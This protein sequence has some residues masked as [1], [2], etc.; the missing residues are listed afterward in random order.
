[1]DGTNT[2]TALPF[3]GDYIRYTN[4]LFTNL[5]FWQKIVGE[6]VLIF[7][8]DSI[9]CSNT[10]H[11]I[12]DYVQYD[13]IGAPWRA[14]LKTPV[15]VGNGGFSFRSKIKTIKLLEKIQYDESTPEDVW[16]G[17][18]LPLVNG[19]VAPPEIAKTFSVET[20]YYEK[21]MALHKLSLRKAD[22]KKLCDKCPEAMYIPPFCKK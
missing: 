20:L 13:Y 11:K 1:M 4:L 10:P 21:P 19:T 9:F 3:R 18:N 17:V 6:K 8:L 7:Q 16:Y 22:I 12:E 5:K 14:S 2:K 15:P